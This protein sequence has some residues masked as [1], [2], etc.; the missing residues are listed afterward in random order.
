MKKKSTTPEQPKF[1]TDLDVDEA[2][3]TEKEIT[4]YVEIPKCIVHKGTI[5]GANYMCPTCKTLYCFSCATT[6]ARSGEKC[7][8]CGAT[9]EIPVTK[10][11]SNP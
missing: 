11:D 7:W 6:L 2:L 3:K 4:K 10:D 9:I 5:A 8:A 1:P